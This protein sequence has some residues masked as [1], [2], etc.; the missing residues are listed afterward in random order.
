MTERISDEIDLEV[1]LIRT[2][3]FLKA[4]LKVLSIAGIIG[5]TLFTVT[6]FLVP[7]VYSSKMILLSDILISSYSEHLTEG[8]N[9]LIKESNTALLSNRLGISEADALSI[10]HIDIED[11]KKE[12]KADSKKEDE[13][14]FII[15]AEVTDRELIPRLQEGLIAYLRNNEYVK[16]RVQHRIDL[17]KQMISKT[18]AE[19]RSLDSLKQRIFNG[20]P[21]PSGNSEMMLID[22]S[23]IYLRVLDLNRAVIDYKHS[24]ELVN[25]IQLVE[26]F[27]PFKK[28][29]KP[30][31]LLLLVIGVFSGIFL[32]L[33]YFGYKWLAA[34]SEEKQ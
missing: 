22:P 31:K 2:A 1:L 28:P 12:A 26:G 15:T 5:G 25:S 13:M 32:T 18:E 16:I 23:A 7:Q 4:K 24:L 9:Q 19:I 14:I 10:K 6:S 8:L 11:I 29:D 33:L 34:K 21:V 3:R 27:T 20:R 17:Y 30:N